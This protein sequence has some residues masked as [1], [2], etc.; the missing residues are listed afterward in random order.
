M[1]IEKQKKKKKN[2]LEVG[3]STDIEHINKMKC[4]K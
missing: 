4:H 1:I 2:E 3:N